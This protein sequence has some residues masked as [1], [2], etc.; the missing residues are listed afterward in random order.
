MALEN[1][2]KLCRYSIDYKGFKMVSIV[3]AHG[4][5]LYSFRL[6]FTGRTDSGMQRKLN[7]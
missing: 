1:Q 7:V 5:F 4:T 6:N 3:K 2:I